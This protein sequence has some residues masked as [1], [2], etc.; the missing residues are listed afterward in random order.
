[1]GRFFYFAMCVFLLVSFLWLEAGSVSALVRD[2]SGVGEVN[3]DHLK[4]AGVL[5]LLAY[6]YHVATAKL[7]E[8]VRVFLVMLAPILTIAIGIWSVWMPV[9]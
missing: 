9:Y 1:M 2:Y 6:G 8:P 4:D 3:W 7:S 5:P